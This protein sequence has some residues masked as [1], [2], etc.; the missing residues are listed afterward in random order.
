MFRVVGWLLAWHLDPTCQEDFSHLLFI[1][2]P[3][4]HN[5]PTCQICLYLVPPTSSLSPIRFGIRFFPIVAPRRCL[6]RARRAV[7]R[8]ARAATELV[9]P[10]AAR[11]RILDRGRCPQ[12]PLAAG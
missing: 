12:A 9:V 1:F 4:H 8:V 10:S 6:G 3:P 2:L 7:Q 5:G 11:R